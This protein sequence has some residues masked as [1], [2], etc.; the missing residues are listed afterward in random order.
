MEDAS[1][2]SCARA[3]LSRV[4]HFGTCLHITSDCGKQFVSNTWRELFNL[5]GVQIFTTL[6]Y[7]PSQNGLVERWDR[8]MKGSL[9]ATLQGYPN[10]PDALPIVL[11]GLGASFKPDNESS[12]AEL[13]VGEP[14]R[15]PGQFFDSH[16]SSSP[17]GDFAQQLRSTM[18]KLRPTSTAWHQPAVGA[19]VFT[20]PSMHAGTH[21][22]VRT[23]VHRTSF[24]P[25]YEAFKGDLSR[26]SFTWKVIRT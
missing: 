8:S 13:V 16:P 25:P 15:L 11:M 10:W 3:L 4:S 2:V 23:D 24:Q 21:V 12:A 6:A 17:A 20:S 22:F 18:A 19:P 14:V 9:M 26:F 1:S 7:E 5:L